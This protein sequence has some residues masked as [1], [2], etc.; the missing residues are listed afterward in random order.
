[1][2]NPE[3]LLRLF[4]EVVFLLLGGLVVWLGITNHIFFDR[5]AASWLVVSI[6]LI[7]WGIRT[8]YKPA[9]SWSRGERWTRGI[10][11]ILLGLILLTISRVPFVWVGPLLAVGGTLLVLRGIAG[12][13]LVLRSR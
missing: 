11:L 8:A 9:K 3:Q 13:V 6:V 1:M 10:S 5:R 2:L 7:L 12:S 4:I